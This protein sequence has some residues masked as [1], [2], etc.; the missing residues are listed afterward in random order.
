MV[1][2]FFGFFL[3]LFLFFRGFSRKVLF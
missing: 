1:Q 3:G 2:P